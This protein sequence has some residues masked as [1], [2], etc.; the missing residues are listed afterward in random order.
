MRR[1]VQFETIKAEFV[2]LGKGRFLEIARKKSISEDGENE[3]V[4]ISR[5][6]VLPNGERRYLKSFT[7]PKEKEMLEKISSLL[8]EV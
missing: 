2:D 7:L 1:K 5:G 6:F 3:F 8:M 4:S